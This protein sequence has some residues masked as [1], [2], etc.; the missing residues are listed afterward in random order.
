MLLRLRRLHNLRERIRK[1]ASHDFSETDGGDVRSKVIH[2]PEIETVIFGGHWVSGRRLMFV[3][4]VMVRVQR[5][6]LIPEL[7]LQS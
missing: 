2:I 7:L 5:R 4:V 3:A 6:E 1:L